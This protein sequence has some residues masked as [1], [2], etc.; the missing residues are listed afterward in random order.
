MDA[1]TMGQKYLKNVKR[2]LIYS[3]NVAI[4]NE[5]G[6]FIFKKLSIN[7]EFLDKKLLITI[8]KDFSKKLVP[9]TQKTHLNN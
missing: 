3:A 4:L 2:G 7:P 5:Y 9:I 8:K 6:I 1:K